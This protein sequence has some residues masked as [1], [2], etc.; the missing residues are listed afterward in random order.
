M[1]R[2]RSRSRLPRLFPL[3]LAALVA[4]SGCAPAASPDPVLVSLAADALSATRA[5]ELG[6]GL[7]D[8]ERMFATTAS[9]LL[10]DME[11]KVADIAR[12][13]G[14]Y[15]PAD[16]TD[17]SYRAELL[18]ASDDALDAIHAAVAGRGG[19]EAELKEV[20]DRLED[21]EAQGSGS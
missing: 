9:A 15:R 3:G 12:E 17:A 1:R 10:G 20:A 18:R 11:E 16:A 2:R 13:V 21:L 7:R 6:T 19:A 14:L 8:D 4:I 5:A